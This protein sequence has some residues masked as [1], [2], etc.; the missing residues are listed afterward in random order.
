LQNLVCESG[1]LTLN[2]IETESVRCYYCGYAQSMFFDSEN[3]YNLVKCSQCGLL[4]VNPMPA[5]EE[6]LEGSITGMHRGDETFDL[7]GNFNDKQVIRFLNI[8]KV[9]YGSSLNNASGASWLDIGCGHGEFMKALNIFSGGKI[10]AKGCEPNIEKVKSAKLM[11]LDVDSLDCDNHQTEY[12]FVSLLNVYSH[13]PNPAEKLAGWKR[14]VKKG[15]EILIETGDISG[16]TKHTITKPYFLPDHL[17][18]ATKDIVCGILQKIGFEVVDIKFYR[19]SAIP[20][21]SLK[22]LL[23]EFKQVLAGNSNV[24]SLLKYSVKNANK[25]MWIR[26]VRKF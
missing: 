11:G 20:K 3:G 9:L 7:T 16:L 19:H 1:K 24:S 4:Y 21:L 15:G 12:N 18:F 26:A 10:R 22:I 6:I 23:Y 2:Q 8:L 25:D 17:S 13:L 14:L 5:K